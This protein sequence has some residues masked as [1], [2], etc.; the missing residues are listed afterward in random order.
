MAVK[1]EF[2]YE[3]VVEVKGPDGK[4]VEKTIQKT[5]NSIE[6]FE[7]AV[8]ATEKTLKGAKLGSP[9]FKKAAKAARE[10]S[11][12][13]EEAKKSS[14]SFS[15]QL[16]AIPGPIGGVIQGVKGLGGAFKALL[17]NP[18]VLVVSGIVA[19]VTAL[20]KAFLSTKKGAEL[21]AQVSAGIG[22]GL[23]VV[24]DV[25]ASIAENIINAFRKDPLQAL[26]D[27]GKAIVNNVVNRFVGIF[28]LIPKLGKAIKQ[29]FQRDFKGA[30]KTA[31]DAVGKVV[32]GVEDVTDKTGEFI[33][34]TKEVVKEI[35]EEATAAAQ[36]TANL[37]NIEDRQRELNVERAKQNALISEAKKRV[38]DETL[39]YEERNAALEEAA[40]AEQNLLNKEIALAEE[41]LAAKQALAA[42]S[43]S[44]AA[45]LD[46][47]AQLEI[48]L[49]NLRE[50]STNKQKELQD[51]KKALNDREKA[52]KK[53]LADFERQ[54][55]E[56]LVEDE[57]QRQQQELE[58]QKQAQLD[59]IEQL[60]AT[61]EEKAALRLKVEEKYQQDQEKLKEQYAEEDR[62]KELGR[63]DTKLELQRVTNAEDLANLQQL[64]NEKMELELSAADLTADE[65]LLIKQK[66]DEAFIAS[67]QELTAI[68]LDIER[69]KAD[70]A[71]K[72]LE[73]IK[74][75][76]GEESKVG[77]AAAIA[78]A[79]VNTYLG[80][81]EALKQKSTLP[82]PLDV[83]AKVVNVATVLSTGLLAVR[84]I[85]GVEAPKFAEGGIVAGIGGPTEDNITARVSAG[86]SIINSRSK[87][88]FRPLL[89]T[90][91]ELGGGKRF[92]ASGAMDTTRPSGEN[93][94][95]IIK[96]Y[97]VANDVTTEQ[98]LFRQQ[99]T[100]SVI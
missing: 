7:E 12:G 54:L 24:R 5:A 63:L 1:K 9:E 21:F 40:A 70:I 38:T 15:E 10:A 4:P 46:E 51:Q 82:S 27:F 47:L 53:A 3:M 58:N 97:V 86:E 56:Q 66:Y 14:M 92:D 96:T 61:E 75:I 88:M 13:L 8:A 99:K 95:P 64:L 26:K 31:T 34:K 72:G 42:Q 11:K 65:R 100:R 89:S 35:R 68:Q 78:Q 19:A 49:A 52:D 73:V 30:A 25:L 44:D 45:T 84:N 23:D 16:D 57:R 6:S 76:A 67:E 20:G 2:V 41:R 37:Q 93:S 55:N 79:L 29:V 85:K 87:S 17:A 74:Q 50:Q 33:E 83:I 43:D 22:A 18:I 39:S 91:N 71:L 77:K 80:V 69:Q 36:L 81:S 94:T 48:N 60:K 59:Q 28:E 32:L 98:E 90:L 62:L